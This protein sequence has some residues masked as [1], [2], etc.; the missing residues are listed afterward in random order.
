MRVIVHRIVIKLYAT[1]AIKQVLLNL[2]IQIFI[3]NQF[4][5]GHISRDCNEPRSNN[6]GGGGGGGGG[7][8]R[9]SR[10]KF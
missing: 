7:G 4:F 6:Y 8:F 9:S 1:T 10:G 3:N 5:L 2:F